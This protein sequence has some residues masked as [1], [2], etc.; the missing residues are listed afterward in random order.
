MALPIDSTA[1][2]FLDIDGVLT[3]R[4]KESKIWNKAKDLFTPLGG[5]RDGFT[6]I[7]WKT[8]ASHFFS[9]YAVANLEELIDKVSQFFHVY[10]VISSAWRTCGDVE[11]L[12][13]NV[14][15]QYS[16][17]KYIKDKTPHFK[18]R[19]RALE[20]N[21]WLKKY[22]EECRVKSFVILDDRDE[23]LSTLYS[24]HFVKTHPITLL[25]KNDIKKAQEKIFKG[26]NP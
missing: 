8:A 7:Q 10:I 23:Y 22:R 12:K 26:L 20:I 24:E 19:P 25:S 11:D 6:S 3:R 5:T 9:K 13:N 15:A 18:D 4:H 21:F 14:F 2:I 1:V 17:S 16:F